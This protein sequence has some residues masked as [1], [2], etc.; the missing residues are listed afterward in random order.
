MKNK[1]TAPDPTPRNK[2]RKWAKGKT[3]KTE[4]RYL[5]RSKS[6]IER[7]I[8]EAERIKREKKLQLKN[9]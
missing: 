7:Q 3:S 8:K 1:E 4:V 6:R 9:K 2:F 5:S